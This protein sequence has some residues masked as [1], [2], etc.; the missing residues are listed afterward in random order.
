MCDIPPLFVLTARVQAELDAER[1]RIEAALTK[2][3]SEE[4][5]SDLDKQ[6]KALRAARTN[7]KPVPLGY[8][9]KPNVE[10]PPK[11]L[12]TYVR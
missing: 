5:M 11:V 10:I 3:P 8:T 4:F 9:F 7:P 6:L 1:A 2:G 12:K